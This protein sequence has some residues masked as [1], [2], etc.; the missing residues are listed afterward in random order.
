MYGASEGGV[1]EE[2]SVHE[3][4]KNGVGIGGHADYLVF[5]KVTLVIWIYSILY[6]HIRVWG[7]ELFSFEA[8]RRQDEVQVEVQHDVQI[9]LW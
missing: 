5:Q 9:K 4:K 6:V 7:L 1:E 2:D 3:F 8:K